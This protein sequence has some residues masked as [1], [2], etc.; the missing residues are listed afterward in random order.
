MSRGLCWSFVGESCCARMEAN[1]TVKG[2]PARVWWVGF[3]V[4]KVGSQ[5]PQGGVGREMA[6]AS[7]F[8]PREREVSVKV[9]SQ[10]FTLSK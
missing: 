4:S 8:T 2:S 5:C 3:G 9:A 1:L 10:V 6:L 7:S